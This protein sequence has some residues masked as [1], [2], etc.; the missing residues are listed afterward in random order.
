MRENGK[1]QVWI[2]IS[3][4]RGWLMTRKP[5]RLIGEQMVMVIWEFGSV[6]AL[7]CMYL[8]SCVFVIFNTGIYRAFRRSSTTK[9]VPCFSMAVYTLVRSIHGSKKTRH[10]WFSVSCSF[11]RWTILMLSEC[12]LDFVYTTT[13]SSFIFLCILPDWFFV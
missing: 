10:F 8:D 5:L 1:T 12:P 3:Y 6:S 2:T 7:E 13:S 4:S 9:H 11:K